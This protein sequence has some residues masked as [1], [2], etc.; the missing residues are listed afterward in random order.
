MS[1]PESATMEAE[2]HFVR[3]SKDEKWAMY[4]GYLCDED[5]WEQPPSDFD[6]PVE[7]E[8]RWTKV[9]TRTKEFLETVTLDGISQTCGARHWLRRLVWLAF[10]TLCTV[11][12]LMQC[13]EVYNEYIGYPK[14]VSVQLQTERPAQF[15]AVTLC[16]LNPINNEEKL[17]NDSVYGAF[18]DV[19]EKNTVTGEH[20]I[21]LCN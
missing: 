12:G 6:A 11:Y 3:S 17:R 14:A 13:Y 21:R 15:P 8:T 5:S 1:S 9:K 2:V 18:I 4:H 20:S 16:N 19:Q 7:P 10:F